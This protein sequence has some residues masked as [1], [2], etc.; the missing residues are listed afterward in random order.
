MFGKSLGSCSEKLAEEVKP[1]AMEVEG[2]EPKPE[3]ME[4]EGGAPKPPGYNAEID[5]LIR[6]YHRF[7][8]LG[9]SEKIKGIWNSVF[10]RV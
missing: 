6:T 5:I 3:S 2:G 8:K 10:Y 9:K 4:V 1:E 7:L